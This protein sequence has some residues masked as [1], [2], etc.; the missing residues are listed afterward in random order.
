MV[1][2][3]DERGQRPYRLVIENDKNLVVESFVA[4]GV[5]DGKTGVVEDAPIDAFSIS[6]CSEMIIVPLDPKLH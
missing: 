5:P 4:T 1:R 2:V 6:K 3:Y